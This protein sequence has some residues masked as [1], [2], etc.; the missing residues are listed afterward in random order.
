[1]HSILEGV[2]KTFFKYWFES[3]IRAEYSLKKYMREIDKRILTIRPPKFVPT[4][5]RSIYLS[6]F[7]RAH[8]YLSF[9]LYY[10][11]PVFRDI[12]HQKFYNNIK[13]LVV[14]IEII[15][16]PSINS[17]SLKIAETII[18][19]FVEEVAQLYPISIQLSGL[20]ELL[21]IVDCTFDFGPLN[22]INC[23]QFEELNRKLIIF[24]HGYDLIGEELIKIFLNAQSLSS[25]SSNL[26]NMKLQ[27]FINR[28]LI[29]KTSNK[30][31]LSSSNKTSFRKIIKTKNSEFHKIFENF[32][33]IPKL[34]LFICHKISYN[35]IIYTSTDKVT[36]R[37]DSSFI[38]N[39]NQHGLINC[40]VIEDDK[41]Y[42]IA[43]RIIPMFN[44][45]YS[46]N[47][48][49]KSFVCYLSNQ[50]FVE[51]IERIK[52]TFLINISENNCFVSLF[53][54]AHLFN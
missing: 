21:H 14:F 40:F 53:S 6:N 13:K 27:E 42:V 34:E 11:L 39:Q 29:F 36:K 1:M 33:G 49:S 22:V 17:D 23:F 52:K 24:L 28:K 30:K 48:E 26:V 51:K 9:I 35:G 10:A 38:N 45:F 43:K 2:V 37:A 5:P 8:E 41:I 54:M 15:L 19:D 46:K 47:V 16:A 32:I 7:W 20:H 18:I 3:D 4:T 12:M 44:S 25:F 50:Y 31:R